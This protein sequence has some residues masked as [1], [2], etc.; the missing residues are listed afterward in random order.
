MASPPSGSP[1]SDKP[2]FPEIYKKIYEIIAMENRLPPPNEI[3]VSGKPPLE[4]PNTVAGSADIDNRLLWFREEPP[5][6]L[7]LPTS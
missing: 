7:C 4:F 2:W 3:L 5:T 1:L 6:Q